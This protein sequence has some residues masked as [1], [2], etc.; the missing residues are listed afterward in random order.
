M[1]ITM[2]MTDSNKNNLASSAV[3]STTGS[4]TSVG[5]TGTTAAIDPN[6]LLSICFKINESITRLDKSLK[7]LQLRFTTLNYVCIDSE[8]DP[9]PVNCLGDLIEL[10]Q[11]S[12][13]LVGQLD[14]LHAKLDDNPEHSIS[15]QIGSQQLA[16]FTSEWFDN[17]TPKFQRTLQMAR[18]YIDLAAGRRGAATVVGRRKHEAAGLAPLALP[19]SGS[20][21]SVKVRVHETLVRLKQTMNE[22]EQLITSISNNLEYTK[23]IIETI[24]SSLQA[25]KVNLEQGEK[26]AVES[27]GL[28]RRSAQTKIV[29]TLVCVAI[30]GLVLVIVFRLLGIL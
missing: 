17:L 5:S 30:I 22:N 13:T 20:V 23:Q 26:Y 1:M 28:V 24:Y 15:F 29:A 18:M 10:C 2:M 9:W 7:L 4:Q 19:A 27:I 14:E 6:Q 16:Y 3:K 11:L 25:T 12:L 21:A 8:L